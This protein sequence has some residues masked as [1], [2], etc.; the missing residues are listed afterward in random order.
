MSSNLLILLLSLSSFTSFI[1]CDVIDLDYYEFTKQI[2]SE[3]DTHVKDNKTWLIM[4]YAKWCSHCKNM[5]P[6]WQDFADS[7][8]GKF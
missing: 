7:Y 3:Y 4:F 2:A 8:S 5:M 1:H 6:L